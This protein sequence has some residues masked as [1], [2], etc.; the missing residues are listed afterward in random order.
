MPQLATILRAKSQLLAV[1]AL[2]LAI[3]VSHPLVFAGEHSSAK[4]C[5][6][7]AQLGMQRVLIVTD[8]VLV[9][10]GVIQPIQDELQQ[11]GIQVSIFSDVKPDPTCA[12]VESAIRSF[13]A[14]QCDSV[15]AIGG[16]STIDTAKVLALA[17][18]NN[19]TPKQLMGIMK[20][21]KP[22]YPLFV[23]P[24]TAG[25]GSEVTIAAVISDS[26]THIKALVIDPKVVPLATALD[27][28]IMKG[29]PAAITADTGI[30]ALTHA[31]ESW[32]SGFANKQSDYYASAAMK[33]IMNNLKAAFDDGNNIAAREAMALGSH[34]A[35]LAMN[36]AGIGYVHALAHQLGTQY[37]IPHGRANAIVLPHVLE[38]NRK[39]S[40]KRL[41]EAARKIGLVMGQSNDSAAAEMFIRNVKTLLQDLNIDPHI[42]Q[43]EKAHFPDMI[44]A[45]FTEAHGIYAVPRYMNYADAEKILNAI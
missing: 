18:A 26:E 2:T 24:T 31:I 33:L 28:H 23:I 11:L 43:L 5:G 42:P 21:R 20:G 17:A 12:I 14:G 6:N 34:Y 45:A 27:P 13:K 22:A 8:A 16:G 30:D 32:V 9:K 36:S 7:M 15:L 41:A 37:H 1:K 44:K 4:L 29:M 38:F 3:P 10:I 39:A 35:G 40:E 25:T 19:K